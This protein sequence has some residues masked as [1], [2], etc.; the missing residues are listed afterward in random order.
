MPT[1]PIVDARVIIP[2]SVSTMDADRRHE[3][4][5][6]VDTGTQRTLVSNK[7]VDWLN[8]AQN[9]HGKVRGVLGDC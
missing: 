8:P 4:Q 9:G 3:L 5:A 6:L 2:I 1:I 7:L